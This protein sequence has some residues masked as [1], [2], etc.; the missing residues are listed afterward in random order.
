[1]LRAWAVATGLVARFGQAPTTDAASPTRNA[2]DA[3]GRAGTDA[4]AAEAEAAARDAAAV[5]NKS[6][7]EE[8]HVFV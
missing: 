6:R 7:R 8:I 5:R 4:E 3:A 1:V 2:S